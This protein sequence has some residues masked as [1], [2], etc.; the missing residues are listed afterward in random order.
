MYNVFKIYY[1]VYKQTLGEGCFVNQ[2]VY[3]L[4]T[5]YKQT[6]GEVVL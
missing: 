4:C 5:L 3:V 6:L 2:G 1:I